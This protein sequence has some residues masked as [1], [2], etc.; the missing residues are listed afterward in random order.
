MNSL[1][2]I[3]CNFL[4][5][6]ADISEIVVL[7]LVSLVYLLTTTAYRLYE[8]CEEFCSGLDRNGL[9]LSFMEKRT[10]VLNFTC[11]FPLQ[12]NLQ[13][14]GG[15]GQRSDCFELFYLESNPASPRA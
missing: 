9:R 3:D 12:P 8:E 5:C 13:R 6:S 14:L 10:L 11:F 2:F 1:I 15:G 4:R 7:K